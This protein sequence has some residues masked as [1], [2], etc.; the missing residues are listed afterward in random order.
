MKTHGFFV[1]GTDTGVGK[2]L[3]ACAL[4]HAFS[5]RGLRTIGMKPVA[6]GA[7]A[8]S[9]ELSNDD[10]EALTAASTV[11]APRELVN[12]YC[13][14]PPIAPHLAAA[15]AGV[16]IDIER[17]RSAFLDLA[18]RADCVIV[19]GAGGFRVPLG[20]GVDTSDLAR[21]LGLPVVLVV[22]MRLGCLNH[23]LLTADA[24]SAAGLPFAGW[25]A[26]H[27]D[28]DMTRADENVQTLQ[29]RLHAPLLSRIGYAAGVSAESV[30]RSMDLDPLTYEQGPQSA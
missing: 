12:P 7:S 10:V 27:I 1:T 4:L 21:L 16:A 11:S 15:E 3:V 23:A 22:G 8:K 28:P 26:N 30:A 29:A 17:V 24:V 6:A 20:R 5:A 25:I 14:A 18:A 9:G 19:E 2:T 13:F